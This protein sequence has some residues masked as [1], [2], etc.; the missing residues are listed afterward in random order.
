VGKDKNKRRFRIAVKRTW[1]TTA[2]P[3]FIGLA[4]LSAASVVLGRAGGGEGFGGGGGDGGGGGGG[5]GSGG[6]SGIFWL[7][8]FWIRFCIEYPYVGLPVTGVALLILYK[9]H[10]GGLSAYR[11]SVIRRG[12]DAADD[13]RV[14]EA[15]AAMSRADPGFNVDRFAQRARLAFMKIQQSWCGQDLTAVRPFVSDGVYERF[16]LQIEEQKMLGYR[17]QMEQ[18]A[19][20]AVTLVEFAEGS[21]FDVATVRIEAQAADYRVS[22]QDGKRIS[23]PGAVEPFVEFWSWVRRHGFKGD[24]SKPGLIEGNC[25]NCGAAV[26]MNQSAK[27]QNCQAILRSGEFDWVL[28]EITQQS[29]WRRGRHGPAPGTADFQQNDPGF[30]RAD[31]EDSAS[32]TFWRKS[33]ADW[34]GKLDPLRKMASEQFCASYAGCLTPQA[35]G[36]RA[37]F[38]DCAVG[39]AHLLGVVPGEA[40]D[41]AVVEMAWE[42]ERMIA[43]AGQTPQKTGQR[44]QTHSLYILTRKAGVKTDPGHGVSSAHCP[45]CGAPIT[46]DTSPGCSF[47]GT[48]LND[49]TRGWVLSA[50]TSAASDLGRQW[51]ARIGAPADA[52]LAHVKTIS[53]VG[54]LAWTV[55]MVAADGTVD[56]NERA[57]LRSLAAKCH[58]DPMR[59]D[60]MIEMALAGRLDV[61]DPPDKTTALVWLTTMAATA[62]AEGRLRP[63][64]AKILSRATRQF[65][66]TDSDVNRLLQQQYA[67][68]LVRARAELRMARQRQWIGR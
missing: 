63:Q 36:S 23:G 31:V 58:V 50:I 8:Y 20:D 15:A 3:L 1:W 46:S 64:E 57:I 48:V 2:A 18:V 42:G 45:N 47:C 6:G 38:G 21:V 11:G 54:V 67:V 37:F 44:I 65:G 41:S 52:S 59:L 5:G 14:G 9:S 66:F 34:L 28:T 29:E 60:Q 40:E 16:S 43:H 55:K 19:V 17:D 22:L 49:G 12:A 68:R 32:V 7:I 24:S 51:T 61:P 27:C 13:N 62:V 25:P 33:M 26:E 35:D 39:G 56:V 53:R 10:Q 4:C 30:N